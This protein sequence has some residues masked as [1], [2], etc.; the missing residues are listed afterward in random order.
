MKESQET[1]DKLLSCNIP[2]EDARMVLTN[3]CHTTICVKMNLRSLIHFCNE[4]LCSCAQKEIREMASLMRNE[5][6]KI[7]P[8]LDKMLV[9]KCEIHSP[10]NFCTESPTRSCGRAPLLS[11][12]FLKTQK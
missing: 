4:R 10:Y 1:Y 8:R 2:S 3:A 7:E 5:V 9:P 6:L 11:D 12:I